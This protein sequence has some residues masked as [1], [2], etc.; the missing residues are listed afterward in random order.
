MA[1]AARLEAEITRE[2]KTWLEQQPDVYVFK[3]VGST[4]QRRGLPD[5]IGNVGG[6]VLYLEVKTEVGRLSP[7]QAVEHTRICQSGADTWV[8]RD[9]AHVQA[10]VGALRGRQ[11]V[12]RHAGEK[13]RG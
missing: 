8:V 7:R 12:L 13:C 5:I 3:T 2:I 1:K 11:E 4:Y 9:L 6:Q 10:I